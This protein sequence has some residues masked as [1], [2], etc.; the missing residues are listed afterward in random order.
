VAIRLS[1][2]IQLKKGFLPVGVV[3]RRRVMRERERRKWRK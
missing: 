3:R 2:D 1:A